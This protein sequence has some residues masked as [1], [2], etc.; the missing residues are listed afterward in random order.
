L[1][2]SGLLR[3][4]QRLLGSIGP[5]ALA[6]AAFIGPGTVTTATVAGA[7]FGYELAWALLFAT[8]AALVLHEMAARLGV[9]ARVGLGE[10]MLSVLPGKRVLRYGAI[11]LIVA[12][13]LVGNAAYE[14]GNIAG[15]ALGVG[16]AFDNA[17]PRAAVALAI[18]LV[19]GAL[20]LFGGYRS[21]ERAL[22]AMVA[23]MSVCF[24]AAALIVRPDFGAL[25]SGFVPRLPRDAAPLALGLIGT[26]IVPYNLFLHAAA[27]RAKW[28][29]EAALNAARFDV[30]FSIGAGGVV[31]MLILVTAA[32]TLFGAGVI[33]TNAADMAR[34]LEPAVGAA[35]TALL[36]AGLCA[37]GLTSAV[38]APLASAYVAAEIFGFPSDPRSTRFR[39]VALAVL[40][41]GTA[42]AATGRQ[43]IEIILFAQFANGLL[44]PL[45]AACL[46]YAANRKALLGEHVNGL[47][48]NTL[49]ASVIVLTTALGIRALA[50]VIAGA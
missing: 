23:L 50:N 41:I 33:V 15:A 48:R 35:A 16:A 39:A 47:G 43:P 34:Q 20:L 27:A 38:T 42:A 37:A 25:L 2:T 45:I 5:G 32:A 7:R 46:L 30:R 44:L 29:S 13:L 6:V 10:A 40:S 31:S 4:W 14:G 49:G 19:A 9:V 22:I 11:L 8:A 3:E 26:T 24:L 17:A 1:R 36:A 12:A 21:I 18:A 28:Q